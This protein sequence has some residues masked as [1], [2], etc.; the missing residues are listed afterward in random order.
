MRWYTFSSYSNCAINTSVM[1]DIFS[2]K[3]EE[4]KTDKQTHS[5]PENKGHVSVDKLLHEPDHGMNL[6]ATY[7]THPKGITFANQEPD[8][9]ILL[10][11]RR[12]FITN[13]PW[14]LGTGLLF[15]FPPLLL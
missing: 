4:Q 2:T 9:I 15:L 5:Q 11:L 3:P 7:A 14:I 10:F 6:F 12:H 1:P 8:E 13:V